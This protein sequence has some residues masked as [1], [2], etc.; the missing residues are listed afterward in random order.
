MARSLSLSRL[1]TNF[2]GTQRNRGEREK[3]AVKNRIEREAM[4][5]GLAPAHCFCYPTLHST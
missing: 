2:P 4:G 1:G 5:A 3:R